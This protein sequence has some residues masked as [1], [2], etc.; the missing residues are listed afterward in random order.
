MERFFVLLLLA[1]VIA[2]AGVIADSISLVPPLCVVG[3]AFSAGGVGDAAVPE[4]HSGAPC[5]GGD[6][7]RGAGWGGCVGV[8]AGVDSWHRD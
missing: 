7:A 4:G 1:T 5:W 6:S 3:L 8:G 2:T